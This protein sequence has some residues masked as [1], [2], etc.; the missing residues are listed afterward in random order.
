METC[1]ALN[2]EGIA[3][4]WALIEQFIAFVSSEG[5]LSKRRA[6]QARSWMWSEI[7]EGLMARFRQDPTVRS[8]IEQLE[9][10]VVSHSLSPALAAEELL[11]VFGTQILAGNKPK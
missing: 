5:V 3:A 9:A 2:G 6:T 11:D 4:V 7:T 1:S 8:R 10:K